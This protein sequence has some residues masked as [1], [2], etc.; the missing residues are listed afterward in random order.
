MEKQNIAPLRNL[1][2]M[3]AI[4]ATVIIGGMVYS[5][6]NSTPEQEIGDTQKES[7]PQVEVRAM[8][9]TEELLQAYE[10]LKS[11]NTDK[12]KGSVDSI[13]KGLDFIER[14][15]KF[16]SSAEIQESDSVKKIAADF[17][18]RM[19][20]FQS[21]EFPELRKSYATVASNMLWEEN[22]SVSINADYTIITFTG[23]MFANNKTIKKIHETI[24]A[25]LKRLRFRYAEYKWY[26]GQDRDYESL[27][28]NNIEDTDL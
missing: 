28:V 14:V 8:T 23:G 17:K 12:Y 27:F 9:Y 3:I 22:V 13:M 10:E 16:A 26:K 25:N 6:Y 19:I 11:V 2:I 21:K 15:A 18:N 20:A 5:H 1:L 7:A 4:F 24:E